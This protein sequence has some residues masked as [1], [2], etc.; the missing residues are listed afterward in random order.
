M[1]RNGVGEKKSPLNQ[2]PMEPKRLESKEM[3][4]RVVGVRR[5]PG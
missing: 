2:E 4:F 1:F 3:V 5:Q